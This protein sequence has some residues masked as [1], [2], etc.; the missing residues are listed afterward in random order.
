MFPNEYSMMN[1][2]NPWLDNLEYDWES[3]KKLGQL[4]TINKNKTIFHQ[5]ESSNYIFV[6]EKGRIRLTLLSLEGEEKRLR[7]LVPMASLESAA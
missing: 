2:V 1:F 4:I 5:N 7:L 3:V 6:V